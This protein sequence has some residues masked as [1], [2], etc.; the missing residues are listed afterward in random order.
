MSMSKKLKDTAVIMIVDDDASTRMMATEFLSQAGFTVVE[1]RDG[2]EALEQAPLVQPDMIILDVEMPRLDGFEACMQLRE[3]PAFMAIPILMLT[4]LDNSESVDRAYNAGA[5]DFAT[6]PINWSLLCYRVRYML[7]ASR[8]SELLIK[9]Q[10][11]LAAAQRIANLGNWE[12]DL[13]QQRSTWSDQLY[14]I[15]GIDA[16]D[17]EPDFETLMSMVH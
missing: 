12:L 3:M 5:T 16:E 2:Q 8:A 1:A 7:R 15:L 11:S 17:I 10:S 13:I 6:K 14:H 4:G 9:N